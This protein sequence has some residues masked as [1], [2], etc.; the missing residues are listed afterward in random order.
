[1]IDETKLADRSNGLITVCFSLGVVIH[2][3]DLSC[4]PRSLN[5]R[6]KFVEYTDYTAEGPNVTFGLYSREN[7]SMFY[8][9]QGVP[10]HRTIGKI[11]NGFQET[12]SLLHKHS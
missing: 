10:V 4:L 9:A 1:M 5:H 8:G 11:L 2:V 3:G 6:L 7:G 12:V